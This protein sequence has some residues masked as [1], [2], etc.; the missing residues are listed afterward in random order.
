MA[1]LLW[2]GVGIQIVNGASAIQYFFQIIGGATAPFALPTND[3]TRRFALLQE[4]MFFGIICH[5]F[6]LLLVSDKFVIFCTFLNF[7]I[8]YD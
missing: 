2:G 6:I 4:V 8:C 7:R 1:F 5:L 3:A